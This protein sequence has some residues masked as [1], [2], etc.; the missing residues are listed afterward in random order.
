MG[1][2]K[3]LSI[4]DFFQKKLDQKVAKNSGKKLE[5][6]EQNIKSVNEDVENRKKLKKSDT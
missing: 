2:L 4:F 1:V 3:I 5:T 6:K